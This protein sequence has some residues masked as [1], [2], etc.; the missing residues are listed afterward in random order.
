MKHALPF[1]LTGLVAGL[2]CSAAQAQSSPYYIG[3]SLSVLHDSNLSRVR[4]GQVLPAGASQADTVSTAALVA[5]LDQPLGRGRLFGSASLNTSNYANNQAYNNQGYA[6]NLGLDWQ[7]IERISG[8][9]A[10][11]SSR[12]VRADVRD[13]LDQVIVKKNAE[14]AN[15]LDASISVGLVTALSAEAS[16]MTRDVRYSEVEAD[17]RE[18]KQNSAS[19]GLRYRL[20]GATSVGLSVAQTNNN[21][22]NLLTGQADRSD[23][24]SRTDVALSANWVP[25]GASSLNA[26][27]SQG[28]T[29]HDRF[30]ERDFSATT[31]SLTWAWTPTGKVR[32]NT[33]LARDAGQDAERATTAFSRT[34]DS[35]RVRADYEATGKINT[36]LTAQAYRRTQ[37]GSGV[38]VSGITGSDIGSSL[39]LGAR[40]AALRSLSVGCEMGTERLG[41]NSDARLSVPYRS[42]S[43][44]CFGQ[45]VLQ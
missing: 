45:F 42:N 12:S 32:L 44:S 25:S 16:V 29:S 31:G 26:S 37:S 8:K 9:V 38:F 24:R 13:R 4:D 22:P 40:W 7:T 36:Y 5:G 30:T 3:L 35:V 27:L 19:V 2:S 14:N 15:Q 11:A 28:K 18:Y 1:V 34:T 10:L 41:G 17:Y 6:L 33:R 21:Y 20:G 23:Q 43:V 39:T